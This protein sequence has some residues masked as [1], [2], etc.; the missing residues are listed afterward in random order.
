MD[1][2][3]DMVGKYHHGDLRAELVRASLALIAEVACTVACQLTDRVRVA[4]GTHA[5]PVEALAAAAGAT[6]PT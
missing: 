2:I 4:A 5:D 3:H 1:V 6:R